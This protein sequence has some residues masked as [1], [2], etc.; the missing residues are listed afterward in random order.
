MVSP[1]RPSSPP[2]TARLRAFLLQVPFT[3]LAFLAVLFMLHPP[4]HAPSDLPTASKL[5]RIDFLGAF[6]LVLA[7][8]SLLVG[9]DRGGNT[10]WSSPLA[11]GPLLAALALALAFA[12]V[13]TTPAL[14][15]EPFAPRHVV[16]RASLL[17]S[18]LTNCCAF[19]AAMCTLFHAALYAQAVRGAG[20]AGAGA[21]LVPGVFAGVCGSL[22]A[23][24]A[25]Q[26]TGR[27]KRLT[28]GAAAAVLAGTALIDGV[29]AA[30]AGGVGGVV[31]G[32]SRAAAPSGRADADT[33]A[34]AS[35]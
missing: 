26:R 8:F 3:A 35:S 30:R 12:A 20:A 14:A 7:V 16:A 34:Q 25:M 6:T 31:A 5:R 21:L 17:G 32:A 13:E 2:L 4:P 33:P 15:A 10:A 24:V 23:G 9:L 18:Y 28:V 1:P 22:G 11:Y 27:Y 29:L 19:G